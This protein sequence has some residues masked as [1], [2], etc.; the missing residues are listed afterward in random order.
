MNM[1]TSPNHYRFT[2]HDKFTIAG[3]P[4]QFISANVF[5]V[6]FRYLDGPKITEQ[7]EHAAIPEMLRSG[8][9]TVERDRLSIEGAQRPSRT[10]ADAFLSTLTKGVAGKVAT[11]FYCVEAFLDLEAEGLVV[12]TDESIEAALD[13]IEL[14][15]RKLAKEAKSNG[16]RKYGGKKN[17]GS[18]IYSPRR[19]RHHVANYE[20]E[21]MRGLLS[22]NHRS[23]APRS[24]W[25]PETER[26]MMETVQKYGHI[27]QPTQKDICEAVEDAFT[28]LNEGRAEKGLSPLRCPSKSTIKRRITALPA[29][30][31]KVRRRGLDAARKEFMPVGA[32]LEVSRL[33]ERVEIDEWEVDLIALL[34]LFGV[35][36]KLTYAEKD[37]LGL[38]K[39]PGVRMWL[40][41]AM[42]SYSR[43]I[44]AMRLSRAPS[45][46]SALA[47]LE[48]ML[49][50]KKPWADAVG[51]L[52]P[53][54][55]GGLPETVVTD[56]GGPYRSAEFR[57]ALADLGITAMRAT[58][59]E[60]RLRARI[61]RFFGTVSTSLMPRLS[62]RTFS[63]IV[64]RG[65]YP[66]NQLAALNV[67]ELSN[68]LVRWVVD[69]YHNSC[70]E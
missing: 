32:G 59:G 51:A 23:G 27:Q 35:W 67:E 47:T 10:E 29:F 21:G 26:L 54:C 15:A 11:R 56:A 5:G 9:M 13:Q 46:A 37:A 42:D 62:G 38:K 31:T 28:V 68:V 45:I 48:M 49:I 58:A 52:T 25:G 14:R 60:A 61:E 3:R 12:R 41:V 40:S 63:N 36:D 6:V 65:A 34:M 39:G 2:E 57:A 22:A 33:L 24:P 17:E 8:W 44:L 1:M 50:E 4:C 64:Q 20:R 43:C 7:F 70:H 18:E 69:I 55:M 53:W 66:S 16:K 19:L 30:A